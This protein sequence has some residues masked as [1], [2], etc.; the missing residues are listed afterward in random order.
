MRKVSKIKLKVIFFL[1]NIW[2]LMEALDWKLRASED[3][4]MPSSARKRRALPL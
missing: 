4:T 2:I 1:G 3:G